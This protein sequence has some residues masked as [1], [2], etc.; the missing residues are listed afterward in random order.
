MTSNGAWWTTRSA[1]TCLFHE[2]TTAAT[3]A[4]KVFTLPVAMVFRQLIGNALAAPDGVAIGGVTTTHRAM[5]LQPI[6]ATDLYDFPKR[7]SEV[8]PLLPAPLEYRL[9]D[10]DLVIRD[11]GSGCDRRGAAARGRHFHGEEM[12]NA[13]DERSGPCA[14]RHA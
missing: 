10:N 12:T 13:R 8:L 5:V 6:P 4:P 11:A 3:P 1:H 2:A 7:L 9:V 14:R